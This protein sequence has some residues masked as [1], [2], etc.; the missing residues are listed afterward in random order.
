MAIKKITQTFP[1]SYPSEMRRQLWALC[2]GASIISGFKSVNQLSEEELIADI[3]ASVAMVPDMQVFAGE[4]INPKFTFLT[5]N[6]GQ[7]GSAKIMSCI[8]KA[9]FFLIGTGTPRGSQQGFFLRDD[10]GDAKGTWK[11][12]GNT[13]AHKATGIDGKATQKVSLGV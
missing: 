4:G 2:C 10:S 5:L 13:K 9:G 8:E 6:S 11:P 1:G 7:M 12:T 3:N